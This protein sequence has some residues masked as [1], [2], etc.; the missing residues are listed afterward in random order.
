ME[1][2]KEFDDWNKIKK[3]IEN[4]DYIPY[5]DAGEIWWCALGV[6]IGVEIDGKGEEFLRPVI[7]LEKYNQFGCLTLSLSSARK[8]DRD[9]IFIGLVQN[10]SATTNLSQLRSI[11]SKRLIEKIRNIDKEQFLTIQKT[12]MEYNFPSQ[13]SDIPSP[14]VESSPK[15]N[16]ITNN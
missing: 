16:I 12:A 14:K 10:K 5:F 11:S 2:V 1:Y 7:I 4:N 6:N 15:A 13:F 9:N 8:A 3:E